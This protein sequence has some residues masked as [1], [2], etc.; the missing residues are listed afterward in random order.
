MRF[1][2]RKGRD[3]SSRMKG[4][5]QFDNGNK[6]FAEIGLERTITYPEGG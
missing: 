4:R 6:G 3:L 5:V 1:D 2:A